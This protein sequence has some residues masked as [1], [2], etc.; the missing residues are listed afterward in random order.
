[1]KMVTHIVGWQGTGKSAL[2]ALMVEA[3][4]ARGATCATVDSDTMLCEYKGNAERA[5]AAHGHVDYLFLEYCPATFNRALP[6]DRVINIG[7]WPD[8]AQSPGAQPATENVAQGVAN[9]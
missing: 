2:A 1:M 3:L 4:Q 9:V 8:L 6:G 7:Y 5:V